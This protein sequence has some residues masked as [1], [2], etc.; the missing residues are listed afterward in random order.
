[1][2]YYGSEHLRDFISVLNDRM[3]GE[4]PSWEQLVT[5]RN[6]IPPAAKHAS[7]PASHRSSIRSNRPDKMYNVNDVERTKKQEKKLNKPPFN[8]EGEIID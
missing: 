8:P 5:S 3:E 6:P 7:L 4:G 1:M 2:G